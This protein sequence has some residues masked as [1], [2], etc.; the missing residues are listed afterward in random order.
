MNGGDLRND[1]SGSADLLTSATIRSQLEVYDGI[2]QTILKAV[3]LQTVRFPW[4]TDS[5]QQCR[6]LQ[7]IRTC[8]T[9]R[10]SRSRQS[11]WCNNL[12]AISFMLTPPTPVSSSSSSPIYH[13]QP[14][15]RESLRPT[16]GAGIKAPPD[17]APLLTRK[18]IHGVSRCVVLTGS[19]DPGCSCSW[20]PRGSTSLALFPPTSE[21]SSCSSLVE[22]SKPARRDSLCPTSEALLVLP[23]AVTLFLTRSSVNEVECGIVSSGSSEDPC[24][25]CSFSTH[26]G[27]SPALIPPTPVDPGTG[28]RRLRVSDTNRLKSRFIRLGRMSIDVGKCRRIHSQ[29]RNSDARHA[30]YKPTEP[31]HLRLQRKR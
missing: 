3:M 19:E 26:E 7:E 11:V 8:R 6:Q 20:S 29:L 21:C 10:T 5:E 24:C 15:H 12:S 2:P 23:P 17:V 28:G 30:E 1:E 22:S 25:S 14:L 16:G 13:S 4:F 27:T 9:C 31:N 18:V